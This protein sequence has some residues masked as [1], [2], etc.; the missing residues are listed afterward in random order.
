MTTA[1]MTFVNTSNTFY[2]VVTNLNTQTNNFLGIGILFTV[3]LFIFSRT[4]SRGTTEAFLISSFSISVL[5]ILMWFI[6][7][8]PWFVVTIT[9]LMLLGSVVKRAFE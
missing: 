7:L 1:N 6:E 2:D 8:V 5:S 9:I 4:I 3:F